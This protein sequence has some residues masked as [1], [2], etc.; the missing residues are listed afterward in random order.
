MLYG[1]F[2]N[3]TGSGIVGNLTPPGSPSLRT[4]PNPGD[5]QGGKDLAAA[6]GR[7]KAP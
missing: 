2:N 4:G 5:G 6:T 1:I 3:K 7:K